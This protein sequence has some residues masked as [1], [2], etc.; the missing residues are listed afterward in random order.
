MSCLV[1]YHDRT[2]RGNIMNLEFWLWLII[3][4]VSFYFVGFFG[5]KHDDEIAK[6]TAD[7]LERR[8]KEQEQNKKEQNNIQ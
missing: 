2:E 6:K 5:K 7:E 1:W 3:C 4:V 8:Q